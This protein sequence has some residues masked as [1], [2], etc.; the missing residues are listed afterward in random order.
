MKA[1]LEVALVSLTLKAG[2]VFFFFFKYTTNFLYWF[3]VQYQTSKCRW[4]NF[5]LFYP[6]FS[7]EFDEPSLKLQKQQEV[8]K[9]WLKDSSKPH[10]CFIQ[11]L[12]VERKVKYFWAVSKDEL[13]DIF[14]FFL[15]F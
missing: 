5:D 14:S 15:S 2:T 12:R 3:D 11:E 7:S 6:N 4:K 9:K 1:F 8:A 10:V 13:F